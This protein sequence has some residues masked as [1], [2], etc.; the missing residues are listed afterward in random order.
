MTVLGFPRLRSN[1]FSSVSTQIVRIRDSG[2]TRDWAFQSRDRSLRLTGDESGRRT[3]LPRPQSALARTVGGSPSVTAPGRDSS[4]NCRPLSHELCVNTRKWTSRD[5][6]RLR[7][8]WNTHPWRVRGRQERARAGI[9]FSREDGRAVRSAGWRRSD[10]GSCDR[11][12]ACSV[13]RAPHGRPHRTPRRRRP[14]GSER[15]GD[16]NQAGRADE[17]PQ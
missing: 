13:W 2:R 11:W 10:L 1:A 15:A 6:S 3:A 5:G 14:G 4:S 17:Q 16:G 7:R 12:Q 9:A 8:T